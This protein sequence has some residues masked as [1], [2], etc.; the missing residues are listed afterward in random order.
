MN[1][2][3]EAVKKAI[4]LPNFQKT[5]LLEIALTH[6]SRIYEDSNLNRQQRDLQELQYRRQ[7]ILGDS[8]FN[9]AVVDYLVSDDRFST[10]SQGDIT[11]K[12]KSPI[13]S[14]EQHF[15]FASE[16]NLRQLCVLGRGERDKENGQTELFAEMFEALV[17]A[18]YLDFER[19]FSR[20]RSWLVEC[21]IS[22]A[23][24]DRLTPDSF[25]KNHL[26]RDTVQEISEMNSTE[27]AEKLRQMK[28]ETDALVASDPQLQKL[29]T[30]IKQ[31]SCSARPEYK[32]EKVRAFYLALIHLLGLAIVR[33]FEPER[34]PG[35]ARSFASSFIRARDVALDLA[36]N[37]NPNTDPANVLVSVFAQDL[38]P[39]LK[40]ILQQ[41]IA[42]LPDP[43]KH[44]EEFQAWRRKNGSVWVERIKNVLG[45]DFH[46][47]DE[48]RDLLKD[49]YKANQLLVEYLDNS[50]SLEVAQREEIKKS[51]FLPIDD[52][53][54][55]P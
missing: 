53:K 23:V 22:R 42:E 15:E 41:L 40:E 52:G 44:S 31:K 48:Q 3:I 38:E 36:F 45:F 30:W 18:V 1:I 2:N 55:S 8:I 34:S 28:Y 32:P 11:N 54:Q 35:K 46:L 43:K 37:C 39:E 47:N 33:N 21:F 25:S 4:A 10:L 26:L 17:G 49:Y 5:E 6:P 13:V 20:T 50:S 7:A 14:R 51:L 27:A 12:F 16:L 29:L 19:D 24:N 9:T